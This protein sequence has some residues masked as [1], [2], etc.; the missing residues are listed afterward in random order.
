[1]IAVDAAAQ[2][3]AAEQARLNA[4]AAA[5][6]ARRTAEALRRAAAAAANLTGGA[7]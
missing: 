5:E 3:A 6:Q 7:Q 4:E 2:A 1:V